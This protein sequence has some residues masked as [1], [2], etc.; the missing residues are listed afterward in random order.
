MKKLMLRVDDLAVQSFPTGGR[1]EP[2]GT[3]HGHGPSAACPTGSPL[4][5]PETEWVSCGIVC[6]RTIDTTPCVCG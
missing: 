3:V 5:C 2:G 4:Q 1:R 6:I